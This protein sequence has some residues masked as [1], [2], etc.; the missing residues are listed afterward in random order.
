MRLAQ[1]LGLV[2]IAEGVETVEQANLL[3]GLHCQYAQGFLFSRPIDAGH[4]RQMLID[5]IDGRQ[6]APVIGRPR[7]GDPA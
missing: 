7:P 5:N 6:P 3:R 2:V 1:D 4:A